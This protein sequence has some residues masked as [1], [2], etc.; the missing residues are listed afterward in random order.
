MKSRTFPS[1]GEV[2]SGV[3]KNKTKTTVDIKT[4]DLKDIRKEIYDLS[5]TA[6]PNG[7]IRLS[8]SPEKLLLETLLGVF[9]FFF[10]C[11]LFYLSAFFLDELSLS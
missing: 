11:E 1:D 8:L 4:A 10:F 2:G 7:L 9:F 6:V 3:R 5:F